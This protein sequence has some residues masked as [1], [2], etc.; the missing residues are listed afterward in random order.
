MTLNDYSPTFRIAN[1]SYRAVDE[2][3][4]LT[5]LKKGTIVSILTRQSEIDRI[6]SHSIIDKALNGIL[7]WRRQPLFYG[8][9]S[10]TTSLLSV[11]QYNEQQKDFNSGNIK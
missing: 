7:K 10:E 3:G 11:E 2:V 9:T 5:Q 4:V 1:S 6:K 8:L